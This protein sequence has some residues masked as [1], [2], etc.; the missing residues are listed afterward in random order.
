MKSS[1][2]VPMVELLAEWQVGSEESFDLSLYIKKYT[3]RS[4][5][6]YHSSLI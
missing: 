5:Q 4:N 6:K 1:K 2:V 3:R